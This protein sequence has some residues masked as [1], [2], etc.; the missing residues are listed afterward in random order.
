MEKTK[1]SINFKS[2]IQSLTRNYAIIFVVL[3]TYLLFTIICRMALGNNAFNSSE[4]TFNMLRQ[5]A[6]VSVLAAGEFFVII[7]GM[8]DLSVASTLA[9]SGI[10]YAMVI[11]AGGI[12]LLPVAIL[13]ALAVGLIVGL[14]NG[15]VVAQ[16]HIPPFITTLGMML[17]VRGTVYLVTNSYPITSLPEGFNYVGRGWLFGLP[18]PIF[19]VAIVYIFAIL[20]SEKKRAGRF[21]F[22]VGGNEEAAALSG[23]NTQKYKMLAYA[24]CGVISAIAGIIMAGR[25]DSGHPNAGLNYEFEAI[26]AVVIGGVSFSGGKGKA[27]GVLFGA[28][29]MTMML[30]GMTLLSIDSNIQNVIKGVVFILAIG[31]D[32]FRNRSKK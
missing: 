24:M 14:V 8:I 19:I 18:F 7:S 26:I 13:A 30:N 28:F 17:I 16:F 21:M 20:F 1:N 23:I 2:T 12:A 11:K 25:L 6:I 4:N 29:F 27:L 3:V 9:L 5:V 15:V 31:W 10:F 32:V 22:A